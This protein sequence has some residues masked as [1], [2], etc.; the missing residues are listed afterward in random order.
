MVDGVAIK[1]FMEKVK[2]GRGRRMSALTTVRK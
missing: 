1:S 2:K